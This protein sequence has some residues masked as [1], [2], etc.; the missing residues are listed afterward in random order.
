MMS[1]AHINTIS[2]GKE[3]QHFSHDHPLIYT[4]DEYP[5]SLCN[6]CGV[7]LLSGP[8]YRCS[9]SCNFFLH[10]PCSQ[11]IPS[12]NRMFGKYDYDLKLLAEPPHENCKCLKCE[13]LCTKF[14]YE[15]SRWRS[16]TFHL[17]CHC[18]FPLE[19]S[20]KH[21]SH[22][23]HSL[24]ALFKEAALLCDV[25]GSEEKGTFFSCAKCC[26]HIHQDCCLFPTIAKIN[27]HPHP[28]VLYYSLFM[29]HDIFLN[30]LICDN[31][32]SLIFGA[33]ICTFCVY[34]GVHLNCAAPELEEPG[35]NSFHDLCFG[36][37]LLGK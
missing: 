16:V 14:T 24:V 13:K 12:T 5:R 32:L 9:K 17:H 19:I 1:A 7:G 4:E 2:D 33:Y 29:Y 20:I 3:I 35:K 28:L 23:E 25:C 15:C 26:F 30:C 21:I 27:R 6:A 37:L 36:L 31:N 11:L 22:H 34:R 8:S 10:Q 18:A